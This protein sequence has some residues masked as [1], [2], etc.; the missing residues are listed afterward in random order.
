MCVASR[1]RYRNAFSDCGVLILAEV[2]KLIPVL[3]FSILSLW[4]VASPIASRRIK[5]AYADHDFETPRSSCMP[6]ERRR[7]VG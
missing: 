6:F 3:C 5:R 1:R 7:N 4:Q 2:K